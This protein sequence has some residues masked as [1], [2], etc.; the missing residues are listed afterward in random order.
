MPHDGPAEFA[1]PSRP[2]E[3]TPFLKKL[4]RGATLSEAE[5]RAAF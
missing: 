5:T 2:G 3:L 4:L 1:K